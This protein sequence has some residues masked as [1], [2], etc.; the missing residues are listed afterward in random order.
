MRVE[1]APRFVV[2]RLHR[3]VDGAE[4]PGPGSVMRLEADDPPGAGFGNGV[5]HADL[6]HWIMAPPR[7]FPEQPVPHFGLGAAGK[8]QG[9]GI[10]HADPAFGVE[11]TGELERLIKDGVKFP[12]AIR[13]PGDRAPSLRHVDDE[14]HDEPGE[15]G[16]D[17]EGQPDD[18]TVLPIE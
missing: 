9:G 6:F 13:E 2:D 14:R 7:R 5:P 18:R 4:L 8:L 3:K 17:A 15:D 10:D 1:D 12:L 11:Q 16:D